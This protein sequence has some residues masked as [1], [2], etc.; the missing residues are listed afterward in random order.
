MWRF[1]AGIAGTLGFVLA[2]PSQAATLNATD[3]NFVAVFNAAKPGDTIRLSGVFGRTSLSNRSFSAQVT[4]DARHAIFTNTL[5]LWGIDNVRLLGG[6]YGNS[7]AA[8]PAAIRITASSRILVSAPNVVGDRVNNHGIDIGSSSGVAVDK[9]HFS[10]LKLGVG[11]IAVTNGRMTGNTS[12]KSSS[13]GFNVADSHNVLVSHNSCSSTA[14]YGAAHPDCVQLWSIA[15]NTPQSDIEISDNTATGA[16]QGFTLFDHGDGGGDRIKFLRNR[17]D[18]SYPQGIACYEC[19]DSQVI[20]NIVTT[21]AG[22]RWKTSINV[23][24][25]HGNTVSGN[26]VADYHPGHHIGTLD[27]DADTFPQFEKSDTPAAFDDVDGVNLTR[28]SMLLAPVPLADAVPEPGVWGLMLAG[29]G[30]A[31]TVLRRRRRTVAA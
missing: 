17:V 6:T 5:S 2:I 19:R 25:G 1:T 13:D 27:F 9:G 16:T 22:A 4:I 18:T 30:L 29:F 14:I 31:G 23:I 10:G 12:V 24:G 21:M 20:G 26:S 8:M 15:G 7:H 3:N 11:F 28:G